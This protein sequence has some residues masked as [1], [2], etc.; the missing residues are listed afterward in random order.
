MLTIKMDRISFMELTV[1]L[2]LTAEAKRAMVVAMIEMQYIVG[3]SEACQISNICRKNY[4]LLA[5]EGGSVEE[6]IT[7]FRKE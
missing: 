3:G 7:V 6:K 4:W 1:S 2:A 5:M